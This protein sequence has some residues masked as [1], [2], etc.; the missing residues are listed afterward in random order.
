M[1]TINTVTVRDLKFLT[2]KQ[3]QDAAELAFI[4]TNAPEEA[5]SPAMQRW[6]RRVF[7]R[8]RGPSV[9]TGDSVDVVPRDGLG[10]SFLCLPVGW[11]R[12]PSTQLGSHLGDRDHSILL[13]RQIEQGR[14]RMLL[15]NSAWIGFLCQCYA[16][17]VIDR[18]VDAARALTALESLPEFTWERSAVTKAEMCDHLAQAIDDRR[19]DDPLWLEQVMHMPST[20]D[21]ERP[22]HESSPENAACIAIQCVPHTGFAPTLEAAAL[23]MAEERISVIER[24]M[25]AAVK[26]SEIEARP[27]FEWG[28]AESDWETVCACLADD[29]AAGLPATTNRIEQL[30]HGAYDVV[31]QR[32]RL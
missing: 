1:S 3:G 12:R 19:L 9:S 8:F 21:T 26:L 22:D 30:I 16:P 11:E 31:P 20:V 32:T 14:R 4:V 7:R 2:K 10:E 25:D 29:I 27:D 5:L 18:V 24:C 13:E 17:S 15:R 28:H 6:Q 23:A